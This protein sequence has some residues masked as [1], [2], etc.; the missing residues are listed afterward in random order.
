MRRASKSSGRNAGHTFAGI[1]LTACW[2]VAAA[3]CGPAPDAGPVDAGRGSGG[4]IGSGGSA[5]TS[6]GGAIGSGGGTTNSGGAIGS[7]G[8]TTNSGGAIGSGGRA[9]GGSGVAGSGSGGAGSGGAAGRVG[10]GGTSNGG[11]IGSGGRPGT[12]GATATGGTTSTGGAAGRGTGGSSTGGATQT[13]ANVGSTSTRPQ[14]SSSEAANFTIPKYM[15]GS[16]SWD[17][18][19]GVGNTA[20]FTANFTVASDGSGTHSTVQAALTAASGSSRQY[21]LIKPGN[22]PGKVSYT[23]STPVTLYGAGTD[24]TKIVI[25]NSASSSQAGGTAQSATF[26]VKA[27]GFQM[28]NLTVSNSFATPTSGDNIQAVAL[29]TSGDKNVMQNI[30]LHGFQDTLYIDSSSPTTTARIYFKGS[31][32]EGDTDYI[33]GRATAVFDG[34]EI[35]YLASRKGTGS[36]VHMAPSTSVGNNLGFLFSG[37]NFT[38]EGG[39]PSSKIALGRSWDQSSTSP[40]PNGQGVVRES[41]L[42]AHINKTAPWAAA[43]TSG[44]AY[45]A[46]GNRFNEYCNSGPGA[47]Q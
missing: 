46:S 1:C 5:T 42:G 37:C 44:R 23:G 36:G 28:A 31:F 13:C 11:A 34:C 21:I 12:A 47:A 20:S 26:T 8:G 6:S 16:D 2:A 10:T 38:A 3:G 22:Y 35:H 45:S 43:A 41:T 27:N 14:L 9:S 40:T 19:A 17:P 15:A 4:F 30:R 39:A 25:V 24:A 29:Y 32:I 7:G 18:T 33:F